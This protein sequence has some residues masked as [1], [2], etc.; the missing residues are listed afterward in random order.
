VAADYAYSDLLTA[1]AALGVKPGG[2]VFVTS[3]LA[4]LMRF[5]QPGA[6]AALDA[7]LRAFRELLG[8][9]GTLFV[10]TSSLDLCNT[11]TVFD[12]QATPSYQMGAFS[13]FVRTREGAVRSFHPFWSV[14]GL[15]PAAEPMLG[16]ISRHAYGFNSVFQRF[17][18]ADVLA[19]AIGKHPRFAVPVIH[20]IETVVGVPYRYNKEFI[21]PVRREGQVVR[22]PYYLAVTRRDSDLVRDTNRTIFSHFVETNGPL[23]E[24]EIG[25]GR[26]WS[27]SHKAFFETTARLLSKDIYAWLEAPPAT[28]PWQS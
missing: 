12:L 16:D 8:P 11:E 28:R 19:V 14:T 23:R 25:R 13:E 18:D 10:P 20:H 9:D 3:D 2:E 26:A 24:V 17:V 6:A 22:E 27:F 4:R 1:Y 21:H 15:G 7:H 5:E